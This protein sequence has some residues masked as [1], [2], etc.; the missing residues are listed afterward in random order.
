[1]IRTLLVCL[2]LPILA[3][4]ASSVPVLAPATV[5]VAQRINIPTELLQKCLDLRSTYPQDISGIIQEDLQF[6][7]QYGECS[8]RHNS[9]L[10]AIKDILK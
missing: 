4:C 3:A 5:E 1:M 10:E 2:F 6:I 7:E 9:L 8:R